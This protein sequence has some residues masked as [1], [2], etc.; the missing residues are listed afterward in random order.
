MSIPGEVIK[1][2]TVKT[3][4]NI[5]LPVLESNMKF[6]NLFIHFRVTFPDFVNNKHADMLKTVFSSKDK[7]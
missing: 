2:D 7:K 4:A 3:I 5:G 1:P 6:G